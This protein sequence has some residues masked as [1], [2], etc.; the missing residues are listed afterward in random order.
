M[1]VRASI[2]E[3]PSGP[4]T[5]TPSASMPTTWAPMRSSMPRCSRVLAALPESWSPKVARGSLPPSTRI[6]LTD[7]A[8]KVRNSPRRLR[9]ANSRTWP[10][11]STPVGPAPTTTTVSHR[12]FSVGSATISAISKAPK[13]RRRSSRASSRVFMPG[14]KK[15]NSSCPKYDWVTP[16]ATMRLS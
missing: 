3:L 9:V 5:S 8:S 12:S 4:L 10:A 1:V 6:T 2:L 15:A 7:E 16:A 14:A 11:S 13:M